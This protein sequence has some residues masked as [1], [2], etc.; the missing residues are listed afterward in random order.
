[1]GA[2]LEKQLVLIGGG[3]AHMV[4]LA[5]LDSFVAKGY[6][7]TVVQPSDYHYYSGMGPGMLGESYTPEEIRFETRRQVEQRGGTFLRDKAIRIDPHNRLVFLERS[8]HPLAYDVLSC[9]A[10]SQV[11]SPVAAVDNQQ[12]FAVKPIEQLLAARERLLELSA[13]H[14][15]RVA[16]IGGGPSAVEVAGN[17]WRL[18]TQNNGLQPRIQIFTGKT[19]LTRT[20]KR[21]Q[22]LA[23]ASLKQ[24]QIEILE[25]GYVDCLQDGNIT[26]KNG[27]RYEADIIFSAVGVKPS[28][29]FAQSGLSTGPDG[30]L[31]VNS[32]LQHVEHANIFG[33]GDCIF[34]QPQPLDKVGVY[35]VRQNPVLYH[36]LM[37]AL[38]GSPLQSF[39]P[40]GAYLLVYNLGDGTGIFCKWSVAFNGRLA[41]RLKDLIDRRFMQTFQ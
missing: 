1:M 27:A 39:K 12:V 33:G 24:R 16:I 10:G 40:G 15:V 31:A 20:P 29:L 25:N 41:F 37:A 36:N 6:G 13:D 26:L 5:K 38:D 3:H 14:S 35:A 17:V 22:K 21:V 4:T 7:V 23:R 34:H 9:N 2:T 32:Y 19:L 8:E 28:P 18:V 11:V 30:G